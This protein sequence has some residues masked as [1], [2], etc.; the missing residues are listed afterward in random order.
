MKK[1]GIALCF[2]CVMALFAACT[3]NSYLNAVPRE[4]TA[5]LSI[6]PVKMSGLNHVSVL[7]TLLQATNIS[8]SGIDVSH[9]IMLFEAPDGN[10]G[11]CAK[12]QDEDELTQTFAQLATKN[13]CPA[14]IKRRG[15]HFTVLKDAWVVGWN[16][17]AMLVMGPVTVEAQS[18]LQQ[19]IAQYLKQDEAAGITQSRLYEKLDSLEGSMT[20]VAQATA[21]PQQF[22]APLTLGMPKKADGSEVIIAAEMEKEQQVMHIKGEV[23][24]LNTT[25]NQSLKQAY[26]LYRPITDRYLSATPRD[27]MLSMFL[28]VDGQKFL[29][30]MQNNAGFQALLT[31]INTAIDMDNILRSVDGDLAL[32]TPYYDE[33]R[34]SMRMMAQLKHK[35]WVKDVGYWK[36]SCPAG[37]RIVDWKPDAW[38]YASKKTTFYFG[39]TP[40][41]QFFSGSTAEEASQ[42]FAPAKQQLSAT[43]KN[44][45]KGQKLALVINMNAL[46]GG[47]TGAVT[48][49]L[50]PIFG[51]VHT[52]IYTLK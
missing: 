33:H 52:L 18:S 41:L 40:Q 9:K 8:K 22:L 12:V 25:V 16:N 17:T 48:A 34:L 27:A 5:L 19:Q 29:P 45:I 39:V 11:V 7:R 46:Q 26:Q 43:E 50:Q 13:V 51:D 1:I 49:M 28:N 30:V 24:S 21:L 4:S 32:V 38:Y 14:P 23:F 10:L 42:V 20:L 6:D 37:G 35:N 2:C 36:K 44:L 31:G 3:D 47:K 15:F